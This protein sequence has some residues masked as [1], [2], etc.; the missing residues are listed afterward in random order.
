MRHRHHNNREDD[1]DQYSINRDKD[2]G[3]K[4]GRI[5]L[6]GDGTEILTDSDDTDMFEQ[7]EEDK[8]L[9]SQVSKSHNQPREDQ[10]QGRNER[11]A[12]PGPEATAS[13]AKQRTLEGAGTSH[14]PDKLFPTNS[15]MSQTS[16]SGKA[17][18]ERIAA[19]ALPEKLVTSPKQA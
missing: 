13:K 11:E 12:T 5:I 17:S 3:G 16:G 1:D 6:L 14:L 8:D 19:A 4:P 7:D 15:D 9:E 10:D 18:P 2:A